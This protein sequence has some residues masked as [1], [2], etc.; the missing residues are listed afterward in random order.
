METYT[1]SGH[2][3]GQKTV[4]IEMQDLITG[5]SPDSADCLSVFHR[6]SP[7]KWIDST[8]KRRFHD[9]RRLSCEVIARLRR[10]TK[11]VIESYATSIIGRVPN[12]GSHA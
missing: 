7:L 8:P 3:A 6:N 12:P 4:E 5:Q 1:R 2:V 11:R 9:L 10:Q